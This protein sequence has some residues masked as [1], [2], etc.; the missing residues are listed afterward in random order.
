[1]IQAKLTPIAPEAGG[2]HDLEG[3]LDLGKKLEVLREHEEW[4]CMNKDEV[5]REH[6]ASWKTNG[7]ADLKYR[8]LARVD[9]GEAAVKITVDLGLNDHWTDRVCGINDR[10]IDS[11]P[12]VRDSVGPA[13]KVDSSSG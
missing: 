11:A 7:L 5:L 8:E 13:E 10:Q 9:L 6:R 1:M 2:I 4:K 3:Q 12:R